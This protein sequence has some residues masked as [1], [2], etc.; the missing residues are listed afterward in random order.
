MDIDEKTQNSPAV[1]ELVKKEEPSKDQ[2][3][4][5]TKDD[6]IAEEFVEKRDVLDNYRMELRKLIESEVKNVMDEEI[7][8]AKQELVAEQKEAIIQIVEEHRLIVREIVEEEK[9][10]IRDKAEEL[11]KA[12]LRFGL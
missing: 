2:E 6:S 10:T 5:E 9:K 11:R 12:I 8:K 3:L 7:K 4:T 1:E